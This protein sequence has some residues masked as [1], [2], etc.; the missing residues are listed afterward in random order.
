MTTESHT[1]WLMFSIIPLETKVFAFSLLKYLNQLRLRTHT[2]SILISHMD[3][4]AILHWIIFLCIW[5]PLF[6]SYWLCYL[7]DLVPYHGFLV[8]FHLP[9]GYSHFVS[10]RSLC[11]C[12][13][14][15]CQHIG[16]SHT[17]MSHKINISVRIFSSL[18]AL[19][20]AS[21]ACNL[22]IVELLVSCCF[23]GT[24]VPL[25]CESVRYFLPWLTHI[26]PTC[27]VVLNLFSAFLV[28][29]TCSRF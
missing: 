28:L 16:F 8:Y 17:F 23:V 27:R 19:I 6:R 9:Q 29:I 22:W 20:H 25:F 11:E 5:W 10:F 18:H 4:M 12:F 2:K 21:R 26:W 7:S 1:L 13:M 3:L 14:H 24:N 15:G